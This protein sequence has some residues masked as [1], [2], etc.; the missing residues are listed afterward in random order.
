MKHN[1]VYFLSALVVILIVVFVV[2]LPIIQN[3]NLQEIVGVVTEKERV[4]YSKDDSRYLIW[5]ETDD[6]DSVVLQ[7]TDS[8]L[9]GKFNS[10]D[11]YG[12]MDVG[13]RYAFTVIGYRVPLLT[14]Y[15]NIIEIKSEE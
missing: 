13:N 15:Q 3:G 11:Y 2:V 14:W 10:S 4:N 5:V 12:K 1:G 6:G 9:R 8:L 7:N